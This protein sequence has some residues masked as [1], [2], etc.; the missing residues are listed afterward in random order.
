MKR[1]ALAGIALIALGGTAY[2]GSLDG[3]KGYGEAY[4]GGQT[5]VEIDDGM[6]LLD[7]GTAEIFGGGGFN[8]V[9]PVSNGWNLGLEGNAQGGS[10]GTGTSFFTSQGGGAIHG[11]H[12]DSDMAYGVYLG[13]GVASE[14]DK[15]T[16][17]NVGLQAAMFGPD[18]TIIGQIGYMSRVR[19]LSDGNF[20][21]DAGLLRVLYRHFYS[22]D[23]MVSAGVTPV[24]GICDDGSDTC[25]VGQI[26]VRFEHQ[27][28]GW[29]VAYFA[30][31]DFLGG[32]EFGDD[33]GFNNRALIGVRF[34]L[35]GDSI[36]A[37]NDGGATFNQP[38]AMNIQEFV[39]GNLE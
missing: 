4:V 30:E 28:E 19:G 26:D 37:N 38:P 10:D 5:G 8:V 25:F 7:G 29:P 2:G 13:A 20:M 3:L 21:T 27:P 9:M 35:N 39:G 6:T 32:V 1:L 18:N 34:Y 16:G 12:R 15:M 11:F 22:D 33:S 31:W 17:I 23:M 24:G 14:D 36:R